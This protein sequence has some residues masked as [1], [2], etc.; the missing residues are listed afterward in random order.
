MVDEVRMRRFKIIYIM[1][2]RFN[3]YSVNPTNEHAIATKITQELYTYLI[4][5]NKKSSFTIGLVPN[6]CNIDYTL[7]Y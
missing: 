3:H 6:A 7:L 2:L 1:C 4:Y 5:G